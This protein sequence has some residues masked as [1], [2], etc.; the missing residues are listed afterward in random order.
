TIPKKKTKCSACK[1]DFSK[2]FLVT[3]R[4]SFR[5]RKH[6]RCDRTYHHGDIFSRQ[7][8]LNLGVKPRRIGVLL[9]LIPRSRNG[10][11]QTARQPHITVARSATRTSAGR[12]VLE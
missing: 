4:Q 10:R 11:S 2:N 3:R 5:M 8:H 12:P 1:T 9:H 7:C 6:K